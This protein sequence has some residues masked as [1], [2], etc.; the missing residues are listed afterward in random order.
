MGTL[1]FFVGKSLNP[2]NPGSDN[3]GRRT[4]PPQV[5]LNF[6]H[7]GNKYNRTLG[8]AFVDGRFCV[9]AVNSDNSGSDNIYIWGGGGGG[10]F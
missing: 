1:V 10:R 7:S 5:N 6:E 8:R 3:R 9:F 2:D 4:L